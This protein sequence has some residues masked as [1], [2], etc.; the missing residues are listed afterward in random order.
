MFKHL[1]EIKRIEYA[2][3][4]CWRTLMTKTRLLK[5]DLADEEDHVAE[6]DAS[7]VERERESCRDEP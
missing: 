5:R 4:E 3:N 1:W 6:G 2:L 7:L